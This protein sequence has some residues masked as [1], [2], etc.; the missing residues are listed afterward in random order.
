[1]LQYVKSTQV[2][3]IVNHKYVSHSMTEAEKEALKNEDL[4]NIDENRHDE[5]DLFDST[6]K[7]LF[8]VITPEPKSFYVETES[9]ITKIVSSEPQLLSRQ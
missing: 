9:K 7:Q 2:Y 3:K 4:F 5:N 1:M 8:G 6:S